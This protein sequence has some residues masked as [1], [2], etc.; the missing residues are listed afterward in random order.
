MMDKQRTIVWF[1]CGAASAVAAKLVL[2]ENPDALLAYCDT[3]GEHPDNKRFLKDCEEWFGKS[4]LVLRNE[5]YK[6]HYDVCLKERY[7]VGPGGAK[8]TVEL[9]KKPRQKFQQPDDVHIIGFT[10]DERTRA[11]RFTNNNPELHLGYS[12]IQQGLTKQ[13]CLGIIWKAGIK[14][15]AMYDLGYNHNNCIGCV[16]GK[17]GY[18]NRIRIDFPQHF[19]RMCAVERELNRT[20]LNGPF[21]DELDPHRGNFRQEPPI[22]CGLGCGMAG[23]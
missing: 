5:K 3:G 8:C 1:S 15:P 4:V 9:K 21:L 14:I 12:L 22:T 11:K 23:L 18:W 16:K 19:E 17:M 6:D 7:L 20:V 10:L 13:D 2:K